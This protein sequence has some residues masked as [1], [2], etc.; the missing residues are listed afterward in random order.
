MYYRPTIDD[1][2]YTYPLDF[3]PIFNA[4]THEIIHIDVPSVRRPLSKA[5]PC[6]YHGAAIEAHGG[7]NKALKPLIISQPEGVSFKLQGREISW[8]NW[9]FH[10]GF[11]YREGLVLN[12]VT[13]NEKGTERPIF[14]RLSLSEMVVPYGN[15]EHP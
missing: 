7:F 3:C 13:F 6:N 5:P 1:N 11:N 4:D 12:N 15:P 10:I 9:K 8:V 2:Q 14:W